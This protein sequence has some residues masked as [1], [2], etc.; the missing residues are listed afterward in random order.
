MSKINWKK[1]IGWGVAALVIIGVVFYNSQNQK[2]SQNDKTVL[3]ILPMTGNAAVWGEHFSKGV[4]YF[5][6]QN[7]N[8]KI[9]IKVIDSQMNPSITISALQQEL[10]RGKPYAILSTT[11]PVTVPVSAFA[12]KEGLFTIGCVMSDK[13]LE[14]PNVQRVYP[15]AYDSTKPVSDY[16]KKNYK[17]LAILYGN[18][19]GGLSAY[20]VMSREYKTDNNEIVFT[21]SYGVNDVVDTHT[22]LYKVL[23][24]KPD[25][26]FISGHGSAYWAIIRELKSMKYQGGILTDLFFAN[27]TQLEQLGK[28]AEGIIFTA[29][30]T[31]LSDSTRKQ[32]IEDKRFYQGKYNQIPNYTGI[33]VYEAL[34]ILNDMAEKGISP[35]N[36]TFENMKKFEGVGGTLEFLPNGDMHYPW[37]AVTI[38]DGKIVPVDD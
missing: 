35:S 1:V 19:E 9:N 38:K 12:S 2:E 28:A 21:D 11:S 6:A 33:T 8:A 15:S 20:K 13:I 36:Q 5:K 34:S 25:A 30:E 24:H 18:E 7:P 17:R 22:L 16:A 27:P 3:V 31:D 14:N 26:I 4:D 29:S 32:V 10:L 23:Y 37:I